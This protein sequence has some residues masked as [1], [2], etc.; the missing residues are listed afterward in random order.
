MTSVNGVARRS[1]FLALL[2]SVLVISSFLFI[3]P[4]VLSMWIVGMT[5][6]V[7]VVTWFVWHG[8]SLGV[9]R[10]MIWR[11]IRG[12]NFGLFSP[13]EYALSPLSFK[14]LLRRSLHPALL[15]FSVTSLAYQVLGLDVTSVSQLVNLM[16]KCLVVLPF[17]GFMPAKWI[18]DDSEVIISK[19]S[20]KFPRNIAYF[21]Y[22]DNFID[23][24]AIIGLTLTVARVVEQTGSAV[25]AFALSVVIPIFLVIF[26]VGP[27]ILSTAL[28]FRFSHVKRV[29]RFRE[30]L[31]PMV[32]TVRVEFKC[33]HC[34][35]PLPLDGQY[36]ITCGKKV[37]RASK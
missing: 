8:I 14:T 24:G 15:S 36:C 34:G 21:A 19:S 23:M 6:L 37:A 31:K 26:L 28:F 13:A 30:K 5:F 25:S 10:L 16:L 2:T 7:G 27:S 33:P 22:I 12:K 20:E 35:S 29:Y 4:S 11:D 3:S 1:F 18:I 9:S 32:A 17:S